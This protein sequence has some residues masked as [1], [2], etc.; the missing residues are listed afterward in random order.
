MDAHQ[1]KDAVETSFLAIKNMGVKTNG[2]QVDFS[3]IAKTD[4]YSIFKQEIAPQL[5]YL[6]LEILEDRS[7]KLSFWINI[8]HLLTLDAVVSFQIQKKVTEG[9]LGVFQ[10]FRKAAYYIDGQRYSLD[11]IEHGILRGNNGHPYIPGP[12]FRS[13]DDRKSQV[14]FPVENRIHFAINCASKSCPPISIYESGKLEHQLDLATRN[15][16]D[17]ETSLSSTGNSIITSQISIGTLAILG[18]KQV[19]GIF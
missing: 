19:F 15:F 9:F 13:K 14:I 17:Q 18:E 12:Q 5:N 11:A 1:I 3:L 6:K 2:Y 10:F 8:Y 7:E 4:A 16:V